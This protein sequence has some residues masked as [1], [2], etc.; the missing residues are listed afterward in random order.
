MAELRV[1]PGRAGRMWLVRR[2]HTAE[3]GVDLLDRRLRILHAEQQ[4][5]GLLCQRTGARFAA[6][7]REA[8]RWLLRAALLGGERE[9]RLATPARP[10]AVE[11]D[12]AAVMG[13]RYPVRARLDLPERAARPP[14]TAALV[15][16]DAAVRVA[17]AAAAAHAVADAARHE[18]DREVLVTRHRLRAIADR[19]LPRL[20]TALDELSQRLEEDE[21]AETVRLRWAGA[22]PAGGLG[23]DLDP[24][25]D[26]VHDLDPDLDRPAGPDAGAGS[27][28]VAEAGPDVVSGLDGGSPP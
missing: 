4:R 10:A 12:W 21:R 20:T 19:W 13:V 3:R 8:D 17:L 28:V 23:V 26:T 5:L 2:V 1:P 24:D 9:L 22:G 15:T 6:A 27:D 25:V 7:S 16:A 14:G 18:V 11:V